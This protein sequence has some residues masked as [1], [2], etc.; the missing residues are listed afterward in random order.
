MDSL[1]LQPE[2][3]PRYPT[4]TMPDQDDNTESRDSDMMRGLVLPSAP[5][6][7]ELHSVG[8]SFAFGM[9]IPKRP[10]EESGLVL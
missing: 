2:T 10:R 5:I 9:H 3:K 1:R 8:K 7:A 4:K 6:A